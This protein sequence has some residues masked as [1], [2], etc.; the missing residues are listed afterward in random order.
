L[1]GSEHVLT[2][3]A[4]GRERLCQCDKKELKLA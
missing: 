4:L 1:D 3:C 2:I